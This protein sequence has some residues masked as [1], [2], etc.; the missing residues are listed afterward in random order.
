MNMQGQNKV[1][2]IECTL[3]R[4]EA[5]DCLTLTFFSPIVSGRG[6]GNVLSRIFG[7]LKPIF[8]SV[9]KKALK[10]ATSKAVKNVA[11]RAAKSAGKSALTGAA[12]MAL[13][14]LEG[15]DVKE[16]AKKDLSN[17]RKAMAQQIR[18]LLNNKRVGEG[19]GERGLS[20]KRSSVVISGKK[21]GSSSLVKRKKIAKTILD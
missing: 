19:K 12:N 13:N 8:K 3:F 5:N 11:K 2:C 4:A 10:T 1:A 9:G 6:I 21:G 15:K 20:R 16:G 18:P 14:A 17:A 7:F